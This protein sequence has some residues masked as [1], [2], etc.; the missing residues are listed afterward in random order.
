MPKKTYVYIDGFNLYYGSIKQTPYKWL[1]LGKICHALLP[2]NNI[3][4]IKYFTAKVSG[5]PGY[6]DAPIHQEL[7]LSALRTIPSLEIIYGHFLTHSVYMPI[8]GSNPCRWV[9]VDKTEEKGSDVNLLT[10]VHFP[11]KHQMKSNAVRLSGGI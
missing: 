10:S 6:L 5:R 9:P 3:Y 2:N 7:Y 1:D 11:R 4:S 8:S